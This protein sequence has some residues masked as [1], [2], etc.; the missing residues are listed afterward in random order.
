MALICIFILALFT[1]PMFS[2]LET[3]N[4]WAHQV[5]LPLIGF[6]QLILFAVRFFS[7]VRHY[8]VCY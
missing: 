5:I 1:L 6:L 4:P 8:W 7:F 3:I 2:L